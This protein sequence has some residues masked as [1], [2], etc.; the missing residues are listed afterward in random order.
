M[1]AVTVNDIVAVSLP[2]L[3]SLTVY[4]NAS[5]PLKWVFGVYV[6]EPSALR[7]T[8][9]FVVGVDRVACRTSPSTSLSFSSTPG[10]A[11]FKVV[12]SFVVLESSRATGASLTAFTVTVTVAVS[13]PPL[14]SATV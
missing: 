3:P 4:W 1:T 10:N 14:P 12:S 11:T 2:P 9:P 13:V 6:N 7:A 5:L 8:V